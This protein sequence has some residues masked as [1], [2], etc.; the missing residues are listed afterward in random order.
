MAQRMHFNVSG[1]T[2]LMPLKMLT[3]GAAVM[4][5]G[6]AV[7]VPAH[8][9]PISNFDAARYAGTWYEIA[10]I[11]HRFEKGLIN[12]NA[13]YALNGDGTLKVIN[14]G[15]N[16]ETKEWKQV[17]GKARFLGDSRVA[18]LKVS[19]FGPFYGGYNVVSL[20]EQYQ[21]ALVIGQDT[22]YF[23][24][25]SRSKN[26][27]QEQ[28]HRLLQKAQAMQVDLSKVILVQQD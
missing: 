25:L 17:E 22:R 19:F 10:R 26:M 16:P 14:R 5:A 2:W 7:S 11:D 18:A 20:D 3:L 23:W 15:F 28:L 24:L 27:P 12:A 1:N 6:C 8:I 4:A 13:S 9:Q 21:T